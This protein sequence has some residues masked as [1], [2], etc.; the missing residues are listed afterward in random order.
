MYF[1]HCNQWKIWLRFHSC[2]SHLV[3]KLEKTHRRHGHFGFLSSL[4]NHL[5]VPSPTPDEINLPFFV[6]EFGRKNWG[7]FPSFLLEFFKLFLKLE[8]KAFVMRKH[9]TCIFSKQTILM[10]NSLSIPEKS[11][12]AY[13][14]RER[15]FSYW[16]Q[17]LRLDKTPCWCIHLRFSK[18][19]PKSQL[20]ARLGLAKFWN[21]VQTLQSKFK[22]Y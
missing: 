8:K 10:R 21:W 4:C 2:R 18:N 3:F 1:D 5:S 17:E 16:K 14:T 20:V 11:H 9:T 15:E 12:L 7:I 6:V 19:R 13:G 22:A